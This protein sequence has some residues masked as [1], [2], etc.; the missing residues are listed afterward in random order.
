MAEKKITSKIERIIEDYTRLIYRNPVKTHIMVFVVFASSAVHVPQIIIDTSVEEMLQKDDPKRLEYNWFREQFGKSE[1]VMVMVKTP[2]I[3][4][5]DVLLKFR[6]LHTEL[7]AKIPYL[8]DITSLINIRNVHGTEDSIEI[9]D[10]FKGLDS[11]R[12]T[13]DE[14]KEIVLNHEYYRDN[15]V[16]SDGRC[17]ALIIENE[18]FIP[19]TDDGNDGMGDFDDTLDVSVSE[20]ADVKT[21]YLTPDENEKIDDAVNHVIAQFYL[22]YPGSGYKS[23]ARSIPR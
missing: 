21:H 22:I 23:Q 7:E 16:S 3:F 5:Q 6:K 18:T 8:R 11:G 9:D 4:N 17:L 14:L 1:L 10:L 19:D 12:Y 20:D 13:L 15:I 2:D